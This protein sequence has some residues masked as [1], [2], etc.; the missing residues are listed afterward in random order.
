MLANRTFGLVA[1][2]LLTLTSTAA[3]IGAP[4][5]TLPVQ[6]SDAEALTAVGAPVAA[7]A[8]TEA[9]LAVAETK[10]AFLL[11]DAKLAE[12]EVI[13]KDAQAQAQ[14]AARRAHAAENARDRFFRLAD[15]AIANANQESAQTQAA[16]ADSPVRLLAHFAFMAERSSAEA[17][18]ARAAAHALAERA[19][20]LAERRVGEISANAADPALAQAN[21]LALAE[22]LQARAAAHAE[23]ALSPEAFAKE[24]VARAEAA[25][26]EWEGRVVLI[27]ADA[28]A[29]PHALAFAQRKLAEAEA[30]LELATDH[31]D[32]LA[33]RAET[34]GH[35]ALNDPRGAP[36]VMLDRMRPRPETITD[37]ALGL[38]AP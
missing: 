1:L 10:G 11:A 34:A 9:A 36:F 28:T 15:H 38:E 22:R 23:A 26:A 18:Q 6:V 33:A 12:V 7:E 30:R 20:A 32:A 31:A 29:D 25:V 4:P 14:I 21:A 8:K 24:L 16:P 17:D 37:P 13:L 19:R 35:S 2:C 5:A 3:A 27:Q